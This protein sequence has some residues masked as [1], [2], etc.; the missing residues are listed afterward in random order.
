[1]HV[2]GHVHDNYGVSSILWKE[3]GTLPE[4]D[5]GSDDGIEKINVVGIKSADGA[6]LIDNGG[7]LERKGKE[8]LL[9]NAALM[10]DNG[11]LE[12]VPWIVDIDLPLKN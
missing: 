4:N 9:V 2:F 3:K 7:S 1:M 10:G 11:Q 5:D 12:K 8:T 6:Q